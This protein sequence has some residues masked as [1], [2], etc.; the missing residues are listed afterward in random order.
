M[1]VDNLYLSQTKANHLHG[2]PTMCMCH[3]GRRNHCLQRRKH[4]RL[5]GMHQH[6]DRQH[7]PFTKTNPTHRRKHVCHQG[8]QCN[9]LT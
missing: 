8:L 1:G 6:L 2:S 4:T 5:A 9:D 7:P 3:L